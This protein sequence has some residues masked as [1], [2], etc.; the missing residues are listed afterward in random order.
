MSQDETKYFIN[1]VTK[2]VVERHLVATLTTSVLS[3]MVVLELSDDEV[4]YIAAEP[5]D[6]TRQRD[7]LDDRIKMLKEAKSAFR[8]AMTELR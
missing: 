4:S 2:Q 7:F 3:P 1:A 8:T 6:V 5:A